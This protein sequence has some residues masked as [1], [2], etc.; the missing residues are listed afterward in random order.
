MLTCMSFLYSFYINPLLDIP[1]ANIFSH[2]VGCLFTVSGFLSVFSQTQ[3]CL[4]IW[5][6]CESLPMLPQRL[7]S[8]F[9]IVSLNSFLG[10]LLI[11]ISL[12]FC[13]VLLIFCS[14]IW[15]VFFLFNLYDQ[16]YKLDLAKAEESEIKL[17]TSVGSQKK[18]E[19]SRKISTSASLTML[20][21]LSCGS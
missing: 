12:R 4:F 13:W 16:M 2:L 5:G 15:N 17:P 14:F 21:P 7:M 6:F 1:F 18:Q 3:T 10:K 8:F 20:K 11:S 19:N 9:M